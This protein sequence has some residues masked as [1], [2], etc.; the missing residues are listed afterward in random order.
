MLR[1]C[2]ALPLFLLLACSTQ[3]ADIAPSSDKADQ[4]CADDTNCVDFL[5]YEVVFTDPECAE[6]EYAQ[7]IANARDTGERLGKP[8]NV[9]CTKEDSE[10][11]GSRPNSPQ[12]RLKEWIDSTEDGDEIFL[13]FLSFSDEVVGNALCEAAER[14]VVVNFILDKENAKSDD[15]KACGANVETRG[16]QGSVGFQH[17]KLVMINPLEA[18]DTDE[19]PDFMRIAFGSGNLSSGTHLHHE[20]W[21]FAEVQRESY[22]AENH[23]CLMQ[24]LID[25]SKESTNGKGRFRSAIKDCREEIEFE[26][27]DDLKTYFIP[28]L[29]D[30]KAAKAQMELQVS[31][32]ASVDIAAHRFSW[33][34]MLDAFHLQLENN[35]DFNARLVVDDDVYWL[36]PIVGAPE[37][38]GFNSENEAEEIS[39][40]IMQG[41]GSSGEFDDESRFAVKFMET[42]HNSRLLHHNKFMIFRNEDGEATGVLY[43]AANFTATGFDENLENVYFT[44]KPE[45]VEAFDLQFARFW[46]DSEVSVDDPEPPRAT[47]A[48]LMPAENVKPV[49]P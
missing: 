44:T 28:A 16:H 13:S 45:V 22:F 36:Q 10:A 29:E 6:Y 4:V 20:N 11:S 37:V 21:H 17:I 9:Y 24:A 35:P 40:L 2:H 15:L 34:A 42:N 7:P 26:E 18:T 39:D 38:V 5:S 49:K 33:R 14:D 8:K 43:G 3:R 19:D 30:R 25:P 27:E 47:P 31:E 12:S 48:E 41:G 1:T 46:G 32:A 23:L